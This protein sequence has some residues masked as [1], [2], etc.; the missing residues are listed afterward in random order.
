MKI[1]FIVI[2]VLMLLGA[3]YL[4]LLNSPAMSPGSGTFPISQRPEPTEKNSSL[5]DL[6]Y[7]SGELVMGSGSF[8]A[9]PGDSSTSDIFV[10]QIDG[11]GRRNLTNGGMNGL[12]AWSYDGNRIV[13]MQ[14]QGENPQIWTMDADGRNKKQLTF[15]PDGGISPAFS[16][17]GSK[18]MYASI[19]SGHP[20][21][22][23]MNS[24]GTDKRQLTTTTKS[25]FTR[26]HGPIRWS[27][28]SSFSPDGK[29]IAYASTQSG[30]SEI[31]VMNADGTNQTQLTFPE[32]PTA[33]DANA[34]AWSPD[35]KKIAF[36]SGYETE[37]GNIWVINADGTGRTQITFETQVNINSDNPSWSPDGKSI[38]F[39]SNR[40]PNP[41]KNNSGAQT[42]IMNADGSNP[43]VLLPFAYGAG[44]RPWRAKMLQ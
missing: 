34:P 15:P 44:R 4:L 35:G 42:W 16:P 11:S 12:P 9:D 30:N 19:Q 37:Y 3:G 28:H 10:I 8:S 1:V 25:S 22:V 36:W 14:K 6:Q 17:D 2:G 23:V 5:K 18:V 21:I 43:R 41:Y 31:W 32:N 39:E 7:S 27:I 33:P 38:I 24:D 13:Y 40:N 29:R 26:T 20:E